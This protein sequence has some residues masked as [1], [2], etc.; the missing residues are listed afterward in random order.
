MVAEAL[1]RHLR[2]TDFLARLGGD[3]FG[4]ILHDCE[5]GTTLSC[6]SS[7]IEAISTTT[8]SWDDW[9]FSLGLSIG[10]TKIGDQDLS[11]DKLMK[12]ADEA[13]YRAKRAGRNLAVIA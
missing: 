13:C 2:P 9:T 1:K 11:I 7:L 3:E 10:I 4:L 5:L 8:F 6:A 12:R